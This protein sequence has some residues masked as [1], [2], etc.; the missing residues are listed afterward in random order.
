VAVVKYHGDFIMENEVGCINIFLLENLKER[1]PLE[2]RLLWENVI[3]AYLKFR[4]F[5]AFGHT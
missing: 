3:K 5:G 2:G 4:I 1:D